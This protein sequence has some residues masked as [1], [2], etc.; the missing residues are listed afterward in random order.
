MYQNIK[1]YY[2]CL[3]NVLGFYPQNVNLNSSHSTLK[4]QVRPNG[5]NCRKNQKTHL[6]KICRYDVFVI[7]IVKFSPKSFCFG[8][9]FLYK[10]DYYGNDFEFSLS[11]IVRYSVTINQLLMPLIPTNRVESTH[12]IILNFV[13]S[14]RS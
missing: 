2:Q 10:V 5:L 6:D 8:L 3:E 14:F 12:S 4:G 11:P 13:S 1:S 9:Y 7:V